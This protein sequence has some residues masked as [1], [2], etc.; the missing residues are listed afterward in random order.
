MLLHVVLCIFV[1]NSKPP[2]WSTVVAVGRWFDLR[3][4]QVKRSKIYNL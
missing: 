2:R 1:V 4:G 3:W